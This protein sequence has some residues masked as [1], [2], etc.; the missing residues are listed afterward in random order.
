MRA[1]REGAR[2]KCGHH[3]CPPSLVCVYHESTSTHTHTEHNIE[4][5]CVCQHT[6]GVSRLQCVC[7]H[8]VSPRGEAIWAHHTPPL[9]TLPFPPHLLL[10]AHTRTPPATLESP[11]ASGAPS[12]TDRDAFRYRRPLVPVE[13]ALYKYCWETATVC[14]LLCC[15]C[16]VHCLC[17]WSLTNECVLST[18]LDLFRPTPWLCC[19]QSATIL[20]YELSM[21]FGRLAG[22]LQAAVSQL[23]LHTQFVQTQILL[24]FQ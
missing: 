2:T 9:Y 5:Q 8:C 1:T 23:H 14:L 24:E 18:G 6:G 13:T 12:C 20:V 16:C 11:T 3:T 22:T 10:V 19:A 21:M 17:C 7:A 15:W 4:L